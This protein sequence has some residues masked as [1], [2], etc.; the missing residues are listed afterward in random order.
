MTSAFASIQTRGKKTKRRD[1]GVVVR[2]LEDITQFGRRD[3]ILRVE[4]GRMRN[5]WYPNGLAEYMTSARMAE[6][7]PSATDAVAQPDPWFVAQQ[8]GVEGET[9]SQTE[10]K[11]ARPTMALKTVSA[12]RAAL[13]IETIVPSSIVFYRKPISTDTSA[14]FGSVSADDIANTL[15]EVLQ[16]SHDEEAALVRVEPRDVH[17]VVSMGTESKQ[18]HQG[19]DEHAPTTDRVKALGRWEVNI[20]VR[21][22]SS[23]AA[24]RVY[25]A[26]EATT[27]GGKSVTVRKIV[28]VVATQ[29]LGQ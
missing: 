4:R 5:F 15:R 21:G 27:S 11:A 7:G 14:I 28:E 1:Q 24:R 3:T 16:R 23:E 25:A 26:E 22:N 2:L 6:L 10:T 13:L 9:I 20:V 17:F 12:T 29:E 19:D 18:R 8:D